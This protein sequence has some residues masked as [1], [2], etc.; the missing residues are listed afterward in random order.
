LSESVFFIN[1]SKNKNM[2]TKY[3]LIYLFYLVNIVSFVSNA[4]DSL[5]SQ[6][7]DE[8]KKT[9]D[10]LLSRVSFGSALGSD[11]YSVPK[12][13]LKTYKF[14]AGIGKGEWDFFL[15][16]SVPAISINSADSEQYLRHDLVKQLGGVINVAL[17]KTG[18]FGNGDIEDLQEVKGARYEVRAGGKV[19]DVISGANQER[20]T[21]PVL[22]STFDIRYMIPLFKPKKRGEQVTRTLGQTVGNLSFDFMGAILYVPNSDVFDQYYSSRQGIPPDPT[23]FAGTFDIF[24]YVTNQLYINLGYSFT[25]QE[26][27]KPVPSF[28]IS[29]GK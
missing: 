21:I 11:A 28:S 10:E 14:S 8:Q 25:N 12:V 19:L 6:P 22:Q 26:E 24:F 17:G 9:P 27:I 29:Y 3:A 16:N 13:A 5:S 23:L 18:Y 20:K 1:F 4:Q 7:S 2:Q 15:F